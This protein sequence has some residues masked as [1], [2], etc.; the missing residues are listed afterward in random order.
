MTKLPFPLGQL[1]NSEFNKDNLLL[2]VHWHSALTALLKKRSYFKF[3]IYFNMIWSYKCAGS[4]TSQEKYEKKIPNFSNI[5]TSVF[6]KK[7][8]SIQNAFLDFSFS[9]I[10]IMRSNSAQLLM[11]KTVSLGLFR[12]NNKI[13]IIIAKY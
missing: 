7:Y 11:G 2:R 4:K 3:L 10:S 9:E 1:Q 13:I 5:Q 12:Q 6:M 8:F